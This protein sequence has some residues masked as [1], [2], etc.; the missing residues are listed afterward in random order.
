MGKSF[1][2]NTGS[3]EDLIETE[4]LQLNFGIFI[5]GTLN[6]RGSFKCYNPC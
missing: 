5:D 4:N 2:Y 6:N 1:V 3:S